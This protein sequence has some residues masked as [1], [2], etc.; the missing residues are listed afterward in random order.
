MAA[1]NASA[2]LP[3]LPLNKPGLRINWWGRNLSS[4][5]NIPALTHLNGLGTR[6]L[7][8]TISARKVHGWRQT[9]KMHCCKSNSFN[10]HFY[11]CNFCRK[12]GILCAPMHPLPSPWVTYFYR[13]DVQWYL[14]GAVWHWM[15]CRCVT[16]VQLKVNWSSD[17]LA[18]THV[19]LI[20]TQKMYFVVEG[21]S[22]LPQG[23]CVM[24]GT[25]RVWKTDCKEIQGKIFVFFPFT[26]RSQS[27]KWFYS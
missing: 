22:Y 8:I 16:K 18:S 4:E 24:P 13:C 6:R 21:N 20:L 19:S 25:G 14:P 10:Q 27:C 23:T 26:S 5:E 15:F 17:A 7:K 9:N 3:W 2:A 12:A 1:G 11:F